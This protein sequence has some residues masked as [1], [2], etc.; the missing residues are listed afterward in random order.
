MRLGKQYCSVCVSFVYGAVVGVNA[1]TEERR[2]GYFLLVDR[3]I[4]LCV[5][6]LFAQACREFQNE[7]SPLTLKINYVHKEVLSLSINSRTY[8]VI[9]FVFQ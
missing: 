4:V 2:H 3:L 6:L 8:V 1:V 5:G 7:L 9:S